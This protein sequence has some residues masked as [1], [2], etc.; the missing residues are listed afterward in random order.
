MLLVTDPLGEFL[1]KKKIEN[2]EQAYI[3]QLLALSSYNDFLDVVDRL[4]ASEAMHNDD[5]TLIIVENDGR[6]ELSV[7]DSKTIE[8]LLTSEKLKYGEET[9]QE[10]KQIALE[11]LIL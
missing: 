11:N 4:R 6:E 10:N 8:D 3:E 9:I 2:K 5:S 7:V 1:Y